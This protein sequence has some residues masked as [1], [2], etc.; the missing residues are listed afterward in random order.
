MGNIIFFITLPFLH[1]I[2]VL[3]FPVLYFVSDIFYFLVY[4]VIGYRRKVVRQNLKNAFPERSDA[5]IKK[6]EKDFYQYFCDIFLET[7]KTLSISRKKMLQYGVMDPAAKKLF[8]D[9]HAQN[10]SI[11]IVMGHYGNWEWGGNSFS[12]ECKQQLYVIYHPLVN[13]NFNELIIKMRKRFGTDLIPMK[14]TFRDMVKLRGKI[15]ATAFIA[16]Q[17]PRPD[18]AYW[19]TFLNQ[20]TPVF[21]GTE[22]IA[23]KM[24][25]PIVFVKIKRV[26]RGYYELFAE[27]LIEKPAETKEGEISEIHT[28][29]LEKDI[30]EQPEIWLWSHRRWKHKRPLS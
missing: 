27:T 29:K 5:E 23:Q 11:I 15:T 30:I 25:Y 8:D 16:D 13:K 26:K 17:T 21:W 6:I 1:L 4:Y 10:K 19:T 12:L 14:E 9:Y 18:N 3:P 22:K 2:S 28:R 20:D 7:F 24:N